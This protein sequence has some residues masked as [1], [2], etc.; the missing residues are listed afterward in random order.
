MAT[1]AHTIISNLITKI[2]AITPDEQANQ[3]DKFRHHPGLDP[4]DG[5]MA[6]DRS[7]VLAP[8][9]TPIR[10]VRYISS[11]FP[12]IVIIELGLGI[13]YQQSKNVRDRILKDSERI[14][15]AIE[16]FQGEYSEHILDV[17][18]ASGNIDPLDR[19]II[20][21]YVINITYSLNLS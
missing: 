14:L 9:G 4:S 12:A 10:D 15:D 17:E 5:M 7:F 2:E 20:V 21:E 18:I 1:R 13:A 11:T 6:R 16:A 3:S 19:T 8:N